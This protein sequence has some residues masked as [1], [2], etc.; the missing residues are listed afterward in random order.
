MLALLVDALLYELNLFVLARSIERIYK[1]KDRNT[2]VPLLSYYI[3]IMRSLPA[4]PTNSTCEF[5]T[6][7]CTP[8]NMEQFA[9]QCQRAD[10]SDSDSRSRHSSDSCTGC[11]DCEAADTLLSL[12][13]GQTNQLNGS[14][15]PVLPPRL[16]Y[17]KKYRQT[18]LDESE[19]NSRSA[20]S[21]SHH[22]AITTMSTPPYT[23]PPPVVDTQHAIT[24]LTNAQPTMTMTS[25]PAHTTV[26]GSHG[27]D[28]S[29]SDTCS[30]CTDNELSNKDY[31]LY[32]PP[33]L[34]ASCCDSPTMVDTATTR[35][36][37]PTLN[38]PV[39]LTPAASPA[40]SEVSPTSGSESTKDEC[41]D[42]DTDDSE[43]DKPA[44]K[45]EPETQFPSDSK[46]PTFAPF[47][48][49]TISQPTAIPAS[50]IQ[51]IKLLHNGSGQFLPITANSNIH[52]MP[53]V[54]MGNMQAL[55]QSSSAVLLMVNP[56][57]QQQ[58]HANFTLPPVI[59]TTKVKTE[60]LPPTT[61][62]TQKLCT[63]AP[64]PL[65]LRVTPPTS[66]VDFTQSPY[67]ATDKI[68]SDTNRRR[69]HICTYENCGKTY[70]KS[71]HLK[72]HLRTHTGEKPFKCQW[73]NCGKCFA[74]SDELSRHR[75]THTGEKRFA[76][77]ICDRRFMRSDHLTKHMKRHN[78]NRKIPNW[79]KEINKL[80]SSPRTSDPPTLLPSNTSCPTPVGYTPTSIPTTPSCRNQ[81]KIAPKT[82]QASAPAKVIQY[83]S[84][85]TTT[86]CRLPLMTATTS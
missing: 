49:P 66:P 35:P 54:I 51:P 45:P 5:E 55:H 4:S 11:N 46:P 70:F 59:D 21:P 74:R 8:S 26:T 65:A 80:S 36:Y 62:P 67:M 73:E 60:Y 23:P 37:S 33:S 14:R 79:Q 75:R 81:I 32:A 2:R 29:H 42:M 13:G 34:S 56:Q 69:S 84:L 39:Y 25:K 19:N 38:T 52:T 86:P 1:S 10:L 82:V 47:F 30:C 31:L 68:S 85:A 7:C 28:S 16:R 22:T 17:R 50:S 24:H 72:A 9:H 57:D 12:C 44:E 77:P 6:S 48:M 27:N 3:T 41:S 63:L 83:V 43:N 76:C 71:S 15:K 61:Q 64:A 20:S 40:N 18:F 58:Q 78:G 53:I